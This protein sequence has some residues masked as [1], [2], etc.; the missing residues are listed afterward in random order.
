MIPDWIHNELCNWSAWCRSGPMPGPQVP[1]HCES[2][3][4]RYIP[5]SIYAAE[6]E[7]EERVTRPPRPDAEKAQIVQH[8][9]D[10]RLSARE[11][12]VLASIYVKRIE[13]AVTMRKLH[14]TRGAYEAALTMAAKEVGRAFRTEE[15][16]DQVRT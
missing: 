9:Y 8:V 7:Q 10:F 11:R 13:Q 3:E 6:A 2:L 1:D 5:P 15:A 14:I 16:H 4:H 12:H